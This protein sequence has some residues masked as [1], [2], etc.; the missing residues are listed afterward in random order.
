MGVIF[1]FFSLDSPLD[2]LMALQDIDLCVSLDVSVCGL[3][4]DISQVPVLG[5]WSRGMQRQI[6]HSGAHPNVL[7]TYFVNPDQL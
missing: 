7:E 1:T 4:W 5:I 2:D 6:L 3:F